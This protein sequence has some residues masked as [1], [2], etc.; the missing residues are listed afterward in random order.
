MRILI[1]GATG[2]VGRAVLR[3]LIPQS[4]Q[5]LALTRNLPPEELGS[6]QW[7][8]ADLGDVKTYLAKL[9][10]FRPEAVIHLAWQDIPDFSLPTSLANLNQS[11]Q[12]LQSVI[13]QKLCK[14]ILIA[15]S[16]FELNI[17]QGECLENVTGTPKNHFT[18]AKHALRDWLLMQTNKQPIEIGWMRIFYVYGPYQR[19]ASLIPT[20]LRHLK[21]A[22]LPPLKTPFNA[23]DFI[24]VDDVAD[25]FVKALETSW[26]SGIFNIGSGQSTTVLDVCR[27]AEKT[28]FSTTKLS[29]LLEANTVSVPANL[30]NFWANCNRSHT[31]LGWQSRTSLQDGLSKTWDWMQKL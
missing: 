23:N 10:E 11:L 8:V 24:Y 6:V 7:H 30:L 22:S 18:W 29:E 5:V 21:D 25:A 26:P 27:L 3:Q 13:D 14:K 16:C 4:Y 2:F 15:G 20:I 31:L 19:S 9:E 12:F 1:T 17:N 28:F